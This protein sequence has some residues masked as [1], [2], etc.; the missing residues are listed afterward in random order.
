VH[1]SRLP[2]K[3]VEFPNIVG[4]RL[5]KA[6]IAFD[7]GDRSR[8]LL[9]EFLELVSKGAQEANYYAGMIYEDGSEGVEKNLESALFYYSQSTE[10]FGFVQ[11]NLAAARMFYHGIGVPQDF[12]TAFDYY[13]HVAQAHGH[14]IACFMLGR[15]YQHGQGV[16]K[17]LGKAREWYERAIAKGS[18]FGMLNLAMLE[19]E[20]GRLIRSLVWRLKAGW[21]A[22]KLSRRNPRDARLRGG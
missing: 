16:A 5:E 22:F 12:A 10:G 18:I 1:Q 17:D 21:M 19:A 11:G 8:A 9:D 2:E 4:G 20:E 6:I 13:S 14:F 3:V 15:M 7:S